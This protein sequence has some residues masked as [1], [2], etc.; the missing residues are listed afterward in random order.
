L[1]LAERYPGVRVTA[2]SNSASQRAHIEAEAARRGLAL[3]VMTA[4]MND[5]QPAG[6]FDRIL[7][8]EM[9]EHLWNHERLMARLG[10]ALAPDGLLFVHVF[11]H[12]RFA[13]PFEDR[14]ASD[15]MA[16][17]FFTGGWMPSDDALMQAQ[18]GLVLEDHWLMD[19]TH[20]AR[21]AE[22]WLAN[23]DRRRDAVTP[24]LAG[25]YG[26]AARWRM[27]WRLFFLACAEMFA[28]RGGQEWGVSHYLYSRR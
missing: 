25:C 8:V 13:Y 18:Q 11:A 27:N 22:A 26:D 7:S 5:F 16:R 9:F 21:T 15:W 6:P 1:W 12:A 19:G 3:T 28:Y 24:I 17:T 4:D 2:V 20:Y 10:A 14:G 23:L